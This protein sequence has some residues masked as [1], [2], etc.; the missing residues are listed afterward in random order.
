M[1]F[2][3]IHSCLLFLFLTK[4]GVHVRPQSTIQHRKNPPFSNTSH[5]TYS[6]TSLAP[7]VSW[8]K[9][10]SPCLLHR[11]SSRIVYGALVT[12]T[13]GSIALEPK[14]VVDKARQ[15]SNPSSLLFRKE[16]TTQTSD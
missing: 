14:G 3:I 2:L 15:P 7:P 13:P 10:T 5:H 8:G 1:V 6:R 12:T 16:S 9:S 11:Y 4:Y